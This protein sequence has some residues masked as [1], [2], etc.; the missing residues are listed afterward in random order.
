M[1]AVIECQVPRLRCSATGRVCSGSYF[2]DI[3]VRG[4]RNSQ[5]SNRLVNSELAHD[6]ADL[7]ERHS[8]GRVQ[9]GEYFEMFADSTIETSRLVFRDGRVDVLVV[10]GDES[11]H[12]AQRGVLHMKVDRCGLDGRVP[13]LLLEICEGETFGEHS[14]RVTV[15]EYVRADG[16]G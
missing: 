14:G 15:P 9:G 6:C 13:E 11:D 8:F 10:V 4:F 16:L 1:K 3:G 7:P 12:P 5:S 2:T